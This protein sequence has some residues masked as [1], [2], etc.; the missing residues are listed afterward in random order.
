MKKIRSLKV[1]PVLGA[2]LIDGLNPCAFGA[3]I[4]LITYL[5]MILK[6]KKREVFF[7][8]ISFTAGVFTAYFL[9][10]LGLAELLYSIK[11][12]HMAS[13]VMY[14]IIG[15]VTLIL[16]VLSFKDYFTIK[17]YHAQEMPGEDP[18][19]MSVALKIPQ[20]F[21]WKIFQITEKH[22]KTRYFVILAF[23]T[24]IIISVL[25]LVCTGQIY[26]PTI[27]YMMKASVNKGQ[28]VTYLLLY[29][30]MFII[31]LL[32]IFILFY[33]GVN[34]EKMDAFGKKHFETVKIFNTAIFFLFA[35][36]MFGVAFG[37]F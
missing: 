12:F 3:I 2:G 11:N 17:K 9:L 24:G 15:A 1:L 20:S 29:S 21:R 18:S 14:F 33:W 19:G 26:L 27:M 25:E 5:S 34:S 30:L 22:A 31:P 32:A 8:G 6:R 10:G 7:T 4:F 36:Y 35:A 13:R 23:V 37:L 16:G 28:A